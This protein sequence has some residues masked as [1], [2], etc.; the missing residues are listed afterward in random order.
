MYR[1]ASFAG[2]FFGF[3]NSQLDK[4][5]KRIKFVNQTRV[6]HYIIIRQAAKNSF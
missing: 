3:E 6:C 4:A 2:S 1:S 5:D